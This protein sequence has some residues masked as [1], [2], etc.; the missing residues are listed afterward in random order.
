MRN[1][2]RAAGSG[3]TPLGRRLDQPGQRCAYRVVEI[4]VG[5]AA[6]QLQARDNAVKE[7]AAL[8]YWQAG[9]GRPD[10]SKLRIRQSQHA[11]IVLRSD[12][13]FLTDQGG[14]KRRAGIFVLWSRS[15]KLRTQSDQP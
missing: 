2:N 1:S 9:G 14:G 5:E 8:L 11:P 15:K 3:E 6:L 4:G 10:R 7:Y 13:N 12:V